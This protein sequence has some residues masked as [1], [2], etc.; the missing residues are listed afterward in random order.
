MVLLK[1]ILFCVGCFT[2]L[3]LTAV[4]LLFLIRP[5][6]SIILLILANLLPLLFRLRL[7]R[8][9]ILL[10]FLRFVCRRRFR[11]CWIV[12]LYPE[13][14]PK[15]FLEPFGVLNLTLMSISRISSAF[16]RPILIR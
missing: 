2:V 8:M 16:G 5:I 1:I 10:L 12:F 11:I 4:F 7:L 9:E 15:I 3:V 14:V 13:V 6:S